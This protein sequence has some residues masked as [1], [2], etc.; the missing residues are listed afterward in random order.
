VDDFFK[1]TEEEQQALWSLLPAVKAALTKSHN[2]AGYNIGLNVGQPAGQTVAHVHVHVIPR[3]RGD[4]P[5]PR[6]GVRWVLPQRAP[7]WS[8]K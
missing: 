7:Y 5:D 8:V 4:V 1:L 6:G 3:Y 2:P